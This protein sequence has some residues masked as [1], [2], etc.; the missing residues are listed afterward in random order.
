MNIAD[1]LVAAGVPQGTV[2]WMLCLVLSPVYCWGQGQVSA[3]WLRHALS[4]LFGIGGSYHCFGLPATNL[5]VSAGGVY[6]IMILARPRCGLLSF[7]FSM[8]FL[9]Y[10]YAMLFFASPHVTSLS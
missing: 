5:L 7:I 3:T 2:K 9:I 6:L 10:W 8:V 1:V 4:V